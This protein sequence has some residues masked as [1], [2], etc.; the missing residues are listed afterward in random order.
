MNVREKFMGRG[1]WLVLHCVHVQNCLK[2][3]LLIILITVIA[4]FSLCSFWELKLEQTLWGPQSLRLLRWPQWPPG[5][6]CRQDPGL[7]SSWWPSVCLLSYTRGLV[8]ACLFQRHQTVLT[9]LAVAWGCAFSCFRH[10][11]VT[12]L[13]LV[14]DGLIRNI[15]RKGR[16]ANKERMPSSWGEGQCCHL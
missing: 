11:H 6:F 5:S 14:T 16:H 1:E 4:L 10:I 12:G 13:F 2:T 8:H 3:S 9:L 15:P 7:L